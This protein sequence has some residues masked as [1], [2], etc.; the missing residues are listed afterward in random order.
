M[1]KGPPR[2]V[3]EKEDVRSDLK[4]L[5][6]EMSKS[7]PT[8]S[9]PIDLISPD[10]DNPNEMD[11]KTFNRLVEEMEQTG[12]V[13]AI[14]ITPSE[15]GRF[16]IIGGEHR[17]QGA[18]SLGWERIDCHILMDGKFADEDL[19][20]LLRVR[21]NVIHGKMNPDK[22]RKLYEDVSKRYGKEQLQALFGFTE[23]D[24]WS[25]LTKGVI[26][27][28]EATGVGG[29]KLSAEL[30]K[31]TKGVKTVDGL[32]SLLNKLFKK[33]GSDVEHGFMVF[34]YG[35]KEHIFI[36]ANERMAKAIDNVKDVCRNRD[37]DINSILAQVFE[38][39]PG[40]MGDLVE[41]CH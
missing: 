18:K 33:Y 9:V 14:Q 4:A 16:K 39:I 26:E 5:G 35:G 23:T 15:G 1:A 27:A 21:L 29:A 3:P 40:R 25:K 38:D 19:Q 6:I 17:W 24:A 7:L 22:F 12:M 41:K 28:V 31:K 34:S 11:D 36:V 8:Y 30:R 2:F 32:G 20:K 13:S 37:V 10:P